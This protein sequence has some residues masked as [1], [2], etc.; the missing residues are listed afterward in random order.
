M[1]NKRNWE[2]KVSAHKCPYLR[3]YFDSQKVFC[4]NDD[5][6]DDEVCSEANCPIKIKKEAQPH[7]EETI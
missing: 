6:T 2:I 7:G 4:D 5:G 1:P 3:H